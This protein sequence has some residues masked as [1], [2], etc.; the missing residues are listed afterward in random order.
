MGETRRRRILPFLSRRKHLVQLESKE[1]AL[2]RTP[3]FH[4]LR[5]SELGALA[6]M[7]DDL[8][9]PAGR[10]LCREGEQGREFFVILEGEVEITKGEDRVRAL[11]PGEFFGEIALVERSRRSTTVTALTPLRAF[12]FSGQSFWNLLALN[13]SVERRV[14]Q[15]LIVENVHER[16]V[17]ESALRRQAE[18]NRHQA[19]HD[20][21]TG[22]PNRALF[23][24]RVEHTLRV[25]EREQERV[26]VL[27]L[28]LDRFKE[29]N[30]TLG[31]PAGD[32]L[33]KELGSRLGGVLRSSDTVARL[34][35]DEFGI[36]CE[37]SH[38][39]DIA[40]LVDKIRRAV[41]VPVMLEEL[42]IGV[43]AS[44]G[45]ALYPDHG[46]GAD[47]LLRR[48]DAAMYAAK[49][50]NA[51]FAVYDSEAHGYDAARVTLVSELRRAIDERELVLHYQP[52][53]MLESGAI[54]S[55]EALVRWQHPE[56]GL[57]FPDAFIP[58]AQRTTL[59]KP[60]T[61]Y[62]LDEAVRQCVEWQKQG[63]TLSVAVNLSPR[64]LL[65]TNFAQEVADVLARH[66]FDPQLLELEITETAMLA[67]PFRTKA[68]LEDLSKMGVRLSIDDFGIGYSS[69]AYLKGLPVDEIKIDRSFVMKM[70]EDAD[71]A[72]IVRS[73]IDLAANLGLDVVAEGVENE[74]I[75]NRLRE[76][77]CHTAQGY[78]LSRPVP[79]DALV[80]W[81]EQRDVTNV[82]ELRRAA[83]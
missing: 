59:I 8:D 80:E 28:D 78:Y 13:S 43:E 17:A 82:R 40:P 19:L 41:E 57:V 35:G 31:H 11:G 34:G 32:A 26:A 36:V 15:Q 16:E 79:P 21:L 3:L 4:G 25:A 20:A 76:L 30:D 62:V 39:N 24:D 1:H 68:V 18:A 63:V 27:L 46:D 73:T 12:V 61:L 45:V 54:Q 75:W 33:L 2:A 53:A 29:V 55:V 9:F 23:W 7:A 81:L 74:A 44:I 70:T 60:L 72:T 77:G 38:L 51:A 64:N 50:E 48:A 69:L 49:E 67:N 6:R 83:G 10:V 37:I 5:R 14:L 58:L 65:D 66:S 71:D 56:R 52:K 47:T 22:L 42:V